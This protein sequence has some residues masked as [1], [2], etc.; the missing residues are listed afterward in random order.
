MK[1]PSVGSVARHFVLLSFLSTLN[2]PLSISQA[3][4]IGTAFTYQGRLAESGGAAN[5][6]YDLR[7]TLYDLSAG[8]TIVA[9][10]ITNAATVSN[11]LFAVTLDF[12]AGAFPGA[13]RWLE[14]A[15]RTN[16]AGAFSPPLIPRQQLTPTPY[17]VYAA[18]VSAAGIAGQIAD[19]QLSGNIAQLN[20]NQTFS[21]T[22]NF[23][24]LAN[25]FAGSFN[26]NG[27]GVTNMSVNS[28]V[29]TRTN[30]TVVAWGQN[31]SGQTNV[32]PGLTNVMAVAGGSQHS[33]ALK[34]TGPSS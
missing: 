21:G 4:G 6:N 9:G 17:A 20:G 14:I 18:N 32:P 23:S 13:N 12:G 26:G 34:V 19:G 7:C 24:S 10:P 25:N 8:G 11:G 15:V 27:A 29:V 30:F 28:L 22:V 16:G 3:Q 5:G 33:L 1:T 31:P 2:S